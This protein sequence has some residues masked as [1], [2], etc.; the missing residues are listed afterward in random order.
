MEVKVLIIEKYDYKGWEEG[1][2]KCLCDE[3]MVRW[4]VKY[5]WEEEKKQK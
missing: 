5:Y 1:T 2:T 3:V 4:K